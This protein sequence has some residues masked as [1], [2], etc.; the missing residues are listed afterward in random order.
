MSEDEHEQL[1]AFAESMRRVKEGKTNP[2]QRNRPG[3]RFP[4]CS[5]NKP[6]EKCEQP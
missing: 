3:C 5:C 4:H 1:A 2:G 6:W